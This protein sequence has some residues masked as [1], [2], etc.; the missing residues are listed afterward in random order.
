MTE[1]P[2]D[3]R[4]EQKRLAVQRFRER[5]QNGPIPR[6]VVGTYVGYTHYGLRDDASRAANAAVSR[7]Y[8]ARR[9]AAAA[10][11]EVSV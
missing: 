5:K 6:G 8:R 3:A 4:R 11:A 2:T 9:K 7:A 10:E 1:T